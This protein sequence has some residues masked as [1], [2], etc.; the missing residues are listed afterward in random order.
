MKKYDHL[1]VED[2]K[3]SLPYQRPPQNMNPRKKV[4]RD[5]KSHG[6]YLSEQFRKAEKE[7]DAINTVSSISSGH[8]IY[9]EIKGEKE[10]DLV[11]DSL[12]R[13][14][15][16]VR[17]RNVK[18]IDGTDHATLYIP[19]D[20]IQSFLKRIENYR[21]EEKGKALMDSIENISLALVDSFW[22]DR[23]HMPSE[24]PFECEVW[25]SV[26][27]DNPA[28]IVADFRKI[29]L[30]A[31]I[32]CGKEYIR[33]PERVVVGVHASRSKL[34][35]LLLES[36]N[37]AEFRRLTTPANFFIEE[38]NTM[39]QEKW[40]DD[41]LGRTEFKG[42]GE[43]TVCLL[44]TGVR[45]AHPLLTPVLK[46][47]H[48]HTTFNDEIVQD[49]NS[50]G[51][52]TG[53]A[54]VAAYFNL[55]D[56]FESDAN[57]VVRHNL[58]SVR[59]VDENIENQLNLFGFITAQAI[60]LAEIGNPEAKRVVMMSVTGETNGELDNQTSEIYQGD[61]KPSS[62]SA[63][64]DNLALGNYESEE[65]EPRLLI[66]SAGNLPTYEIE[67]LKEETDHLTYQI[68]VK[69]K[70]IE[71]PA[72][73]WNAL[74]VGAYTELTHQLENGYQPLV[75]KGGYSPF[76]SSSYIWDHNWPLKPDIVLE[77]GNLAYNPEDLHIK[78]SSVDELSLL[79]T[80][81]N[82]DHPGNGYFSTTSMTSSAT[83]QAAHIS[84]QIY[85]KYPDLWAE[86]VRAL[87]V[88]SASW[89]TTMKRQE[90]GSKSIEQTNKTERGNLLK[91]V[92]YG[93]PSLENALHS[94]SNSVNMVIEEKIQPFIKRGSKSPSLNE[95]DVYDLPW[96]EDVLLNLDET[97][98]EM[99]ITL[100]YFIDPS[101]GEV[102]WKSR[103]RYP[104][105]R[106]QF[107]VSSENETREE[108]LAR[109]N[110]KERG[111]DYKSPSDSSNSNRWFFGEN[112]RN[113]GS[114]HKDYWNGTA[115]EL[116]RN[117][118]I[119]VYPLGGWWKERT[120][121]NKYHEKIRY[122]LIISISTPEQDIDLYTPI[123]NI[124][125]K[126]K[127]AITIEV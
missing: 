33:F 11:Y 103:Y 70:S 123:R 91:I 22:T 18:E 42:D 50:K 16:Q 1:R 12:E 104:G 65:A 75:E 24:G 63:T 84:A 102:G 116:A 114:I 44:D 76:T 61:G 108:F 99:K 81:S 110:G 111:E 7:N 78:Y 8:G 112:Q 32:Q 21:K 4:K 53:M 122:S 43:V 60:S 48:M 113:R 34:V 25:L 62:W 126:T 39:E 118:Y 10:Y 66:V 27:E 94:M 5:R 26:Y 67:D 109:I 40:M 77:G 93:V 56:L 49:R 55:Q 52:G 88:H 58:E 54:G 82:F 29:C 120:H 59:I 90:F 46:D 2:F 38:N 35:K 36:P 23:I 74:T 71:D 115:A 9:L 106:L 105:A 17:L 125:I 6:Q 73:S 69:N 80:S 47:K 57:I 124:A 107:D 64:I 37:I 31:H 127:Q 28:E 14:S 100:S 68:A 13:V 97:D 51:H 89:T 87:M 15:Q 98:V 119:G 95:M 83:A 96:P 41:L 101:P 72:Q 30:D 19:D 79:T 3:A 121:L 86:T 117:K 92:G 20:Q 85:A 45:N